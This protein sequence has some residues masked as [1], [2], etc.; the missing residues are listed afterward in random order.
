MERYVCIHGHFYQPPREN[1]WLE[2]IE[3]QDSAYPY[4]DWNERIAA[5]CYAPNRASRILNSQARIDQIVNNYSRMSF[6]FGPT[7]LAW[8]EHA[9]PQTYQAI[10]AADADSQERFGGH[11]SALAQ[12]YNHMI[13]PLANRRDKRT[14]VIWGIRD[15]ELRFAR[16]PEGVWLP[17]TAVDLETLDVVAEQGIK[18]TILSPYQAKRSRPLGGRAWRDVSEGRID[19]TMAYQIRLPSGRSLALFFY[20]GPISQAVAFQGLLEKGE[21]LV[22]RFLSAFSDTAKHAQLVH[23][24]T[25]GETY[26]HHQ[27]FGD[28]ALAYAL[29]QF[30]SQE[31]TRITNYGQFLE[32]HPPTHEVQIYENSSWSCVH[33]VERWRSNCGCSTGGHPGW[34]Q[35]WRAPLRDTLDRLRDRLCPLYEEKARDYFKD[36]WAA[37]DAYIDVVLD[38]SPENVESFLSQQAKR[39][40]DRDETVT[41]LK[42]LGIQ[43]HAMLMYTSCGWFF[44]EISRIET[45]QVMQ[46][47]GRA[48]QL[49][50]ELFGTDF[51]SSVLEGLDGAQSNIP[52]LG[53]G[54]RVYERFV[55]PSVIDLPKV[56]AHYAVSSLF[57]E[58]PEIA[59]VY[60]YEVRREDFKVLQSGRVRMA[61]GR[62]EVTSDITR[63]SSSLIIGVVHLGDHNFTGGVRTFKG[64]E[65]YEALAHEI[66]EVFSRGDIPELIRAVDKSFGLGTYSLKLLFRDQQRKILEVI[67]DSTRAEAEALYRR[68]Y[69]DHSSLARF[70]AE[71]GLPVPKPLKMAAQFLLNTDLRRAFDS[72]QIDVT[73]IQSLLQEGKMALADLDVSGLE[74]AARKALI[75][76]AHDFAQQPEDLARIQTLNAALDLVAGLPFE[77]NLWEPQNLYY[78]VMRRLA[79]DLHAKAYAPDEAS[80]AW[81]TGFMRL[82]TKLHMA[83]PDGDGPES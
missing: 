10:F 79:P 13:L 35:A 19:P 65:E 22:G 82:G 40:L 8:L 31:S 62:I 24:A 77:V 21:Y 50:A 28:M 44:D 12:A 73:R 64:I 56:G 7:L 71:L 15:F 4:H 48:M 43:R 83:V 75:R 41:A 66:E 74:Y 16:R 14:Q 6:N 1:P 30:E 34:S 54:R 45:I 3:I 39:K 67:L 61:L 68:F 25:D 29:H 17:E 20:D 63:E 53:S 27:K 37:R 80:R 72:S 36:P 49:S 46:Y 23:I 33:G 42:L 52:E 76:L 51:E 55:K 5:E 32:L 81:A 70:L 18:F 57:E 26:G 2:A 9:D 58:Y 38:R 59:C 69:E 60:C 78:E 47:A 11:G